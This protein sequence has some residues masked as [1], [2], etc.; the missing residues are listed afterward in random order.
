MAPWL[1]RPTLFAIA[2]MNAVTGIATAVVLAPLAWGQDANFYRGCGV[3]LSSGKACESLYPPLTSYAA[4]PLVPLSPALA[5]LAMSMIGA[6]LLALG[7]W[8]E[9]KGCARVDRALTA[10]AVF[11][12]APVV[13]ELILGQVTLLI[14]ASLYPVVRRRDGYRNGLAFGVALA[15]A[16]KP[17]LALVVVW[18]LVW[19]RRALAGT[20]AV[21]AALT[22][23]GLFL[24]GPAAYADWASGVLGAGA[25]GAG[26]SE[27]ALH[28]NQSLW[29]MTAA[30]ALLAG[31]VVLVT[32]YVTV[33][34][35]DR[36]LAAAVVGGLLVAPYTGL[37]AISILLLVV[38]PAV[39][40]APRAVR[41]L[42]L[43]ANLC[44][45]FL[46]AL[47]AWG[48]VAIASMVPWRRRAPAASP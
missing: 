4:L 31:L 22:L 28:A 20:V 12:F 43:T 18:I 17:M 38:Q 40:V 14:A 33:R 8:L 36:G 39:R 19:R 3:A 10:I 23:A 46:S 26:I 30:K 7:V 16:P 2:A 11:G 41:L 6:A 32:L 27:L 45:V 25:R 34:D 24:A 29:P 35:A 9:T 44:F 48:C 21:A 5:A 37:Y 15:L 47:V 13:F 42:A 1:G